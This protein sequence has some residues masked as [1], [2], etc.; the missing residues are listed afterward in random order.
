MGQAMDR[1]VCRHLWTTS[2]QKNIEGGG[3]VGG[4][5]SEAAK[6][7]NDGGDGDGYGEGVGRRRPSGGKRG[8]ELVGGER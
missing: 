6:G 3:W 7:G 1:I 4:D 8:I 2:K 5:D